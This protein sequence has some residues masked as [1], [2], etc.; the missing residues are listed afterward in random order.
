MT[1]VALIV[2]LFGMIS[3]AGAITTVSANPV[4]IG[5]PGPGATIR[6]NN[7]AEFHEAIEAYDWQG[8]GTLGDPVILDGTLGA[9]HNPQID[10]NGAEAGIYIANTSYYFIILNWSINNTANSGN[11]IQIENVHTRFMIHD[12]EVNNTSYGIFINHAISPVINE[13]TVF[14]CSTGIRIDNTTTPTVRNNIIYDEVTALPEIHYGIFLRGCANG[15]VNDNTMYKIN[16]AMELENCNNIHISFNNMTDCVIGVYID[17]ASIRTTIQSNNI[18][19]MQEWGVTLNYDAENTTVLDNQFKNCLW[20][21]ID[22]ARSNDALIQ[23]NSFENCTRGVFTR[24]TDVTGSK[25]VDIFHNVF[26]SCQVGV[27]LNLIRNSQVTYNSFIDCF[28]YGLILT[29]SS[30]AIAHHNVFIGCNAGGVQGYDSSDDQNQWNDNSGYGNYWDDHHATDLNDTGIDPTPYTLNGEGMQD[31]YPL[32]YT[33]GPAYHLEAVSG[34]GEVYFT[35]SASNYSAGA[36]FAAPESNY[37]AHRYGGTGGMLTYI[38]WPGSENWEDD[39]VV[40]GTTYKYEVISNNTYGESSA[41]NVSI[42]LPSLNIPA[43]NITSPADDTIFSVS[44]VTVQWEEGW[45]NG[46]NVTEYE[47][48][49]DSGSWVD[50]G[51]ALSHTFTSVPDGWHNITILVRNEIGNTGFDTVTVIVDTTA[52]TL[53]ITAPAEGFISNVT[54][55]N[56]AWVGSDATTGVKNYSL[57]VDSGS[58]E[59]EVLDTSDL[60]ILQNGIHVIEIRAYDNANNSVIKMVNLSVDTNA[61]VI[62]FIQPIDGSF[63]NQVDFVALWNITD[64]SGVNY[65][66]IRLAGP[67]GIFGPWAN[68]TDDDSILITELTVGGADLSDGNWSLEIAAIDIV[69]NNGSSISHFTVDTVAPIISDLTPGNN[70]YVGTNATLFTWNVTDSMSGINSTLVSVDS[71]TPVDIG[72]LKNFTT[73]ILSDGWHWFN[74]TVV[75]NAT[76]SASLSVHFFVDTQ[77]PIVA[78]LLPVDGAKLNNATV[79][80]EWSGTDPL[81]AS[82][83]AYYEYNLDGA[84]WI[85]IGLSNQTNLTTIE[86]NHSFQV[87]AFDSAGNPSN[88][89][90]ISFMVDLTAPSLSIVSPLEGTLIGSADVMVVWNGSDNLSGIHGYNVSIDGSDWLS[91]NMSTNHTFT[92]LSDGLHNVKVNVSDNAGNYAI[93]QVNFSTDFTPPQVNIT[94]PVEGAVFGVNWTVV[95]WTAVEN[96]TN[97]SLIK[98]WLDDNTTWINVTGLNTY[99]LTMLSE[100]HHAIHVK[101][102]DALGNAQEKTVNIITDLSAPSI[103]ITA[104]TAGQFINSASINATFTVTDTLSGV[105]VTKVRIDGNGWI[106]VTDSWHIFTGLTNGQHTIYVFSQ[107]NLGFNDTKSV[108]F[109]VDLNPPTMTP[110]TPAANANGVLRNTVIVVTFSEEMLSATVTLS[111]SVPA[112]T[113]SWNA[114]KTQLTYTPGASLAYGTLYTVSIAGTDL[115]GGPLAGTTSW[116]FTTIAHVIGIVKDA[117]GN[118]IA[119]ATVNMTGVG[120]AKEVKTGSDGSFGIDVPTG[121]YN[122]TISAPGMKELKKEVVVTTGTNDLGL[123]GMSAADDWTWLIIVVIVVLVV[124]VALFVLLRRRP[125]A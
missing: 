37:I 96:A 84:G 64:A 115:A 89:P 26:T 61:P 33:I 5:F 62:S 43:V 94:R 108:V 90:S 65:S 31:L 9:I 55:V 69:G 50:V 100:G 11:G 67:N 22:I 116:T 101:A 57:R 14:N 13:S 4:S 79:L 75:D 102:Y 1:I 19:N 41:R 76:N 47:A 8:A 3:L 16:E 103:V 18:E 46:F 44:S 56:V 2:A 74:L 21:G 6:I 105:N 72:Y 39:T 112:G 35:W 60:V 63:T 88:E 92:G 122:L 24:D 87:R 70:S 106:N 83:I 59:D 68:V 52:P 58:W 25:R 111:P 10:M 80:F 93:G 99:N 110:V 77:A 51:L 73:E 71:S 107:D 20:S 42:T 91:V 12:I 66:W 82:G 97:V 85:N 118:P 40:P 86:G 123:Q 121:V 81:P 38:T 125:R 7:D 54:S 109:N 48:R 124:V 114:A 104:P 120:F 34:A 49:L 27:N 28:G 17:Q 15:F 45:G 119:N 117:N 95:E 53:V 30:G 32:S 23:G 78:I 36:L 29:N 113:Y 98:L